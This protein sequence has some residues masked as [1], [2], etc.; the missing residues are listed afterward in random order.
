MVAGPEPAI[1][2]CAGA[3]I[4]EKSWAQAE[5][6]GRHKEINIMILSTSEIAVCRRASAGE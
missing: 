3:E 6:E 1:T 5:V 4:R 2:P